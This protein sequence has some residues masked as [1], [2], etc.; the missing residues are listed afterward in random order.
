MTIPDEIGRVYRALARGLAT[1]GAVIVLL[2]QDDDVDLARLVADVS[3]PMAGMAEL[4]VV[5]ACREYEAWF[6]GSIESLRL[7]SG[8]RDDA[9]FGG[10]PEA[11]RDAKGR[12][13]QLMH[14]PYRE[15]L[16]QPAFS[17]LL[18]L[19]EARRRCP[20]FDFLVR[21]IG[22]LIGAPEER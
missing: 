2:D 3:A 10:D 19:D 1:D 4:R 18:A 16:H 7:H 6:L 5:V 11:P 22:E 14:E 21:A 15:T 13:R 8:V 12:L 17:E 9:S 20:S